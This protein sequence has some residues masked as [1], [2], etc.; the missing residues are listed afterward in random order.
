MP[1]TIATLLM[2]IEA[3]RHDDVQMILRSRHRNIEEPP[4][5]F[6]LSRA[7]NRQ[8]GWYTTVHAIK[9]ENRLPLLPFG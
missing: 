6:D 8:I 4:F 2:G 7:A 9:N 5:F 3:L 1:V